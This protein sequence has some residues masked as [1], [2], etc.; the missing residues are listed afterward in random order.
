MHLLGYDIGSSSIKGTIIDA[1]TGGIIA[2]ASHPSKEMEIIAKKPGWAEQEPQVWWDNIVAVTGRLKKIA[3][4]K[5]DDIE[6]IGISYQMHG[7]VCVDI[8]HKSLRPSIIW[9]DSRA[10]PYGK[11][12]EEKIG[13][14]KCLETLL[15]LPGN[16]TAAKLAWVKENEPSTYKKIYKVMLPGDYAAMRM[17]G[18]ICTSIS[19]LSEGMFWDFKKQAVSEP[20]LKAF[21]FD[22]ELTARFTPSFSVN[23]TLTNGA[24]KELGLK[25]G[26][27]VA[28]RAGDQPNNAL[29]LNVLEPGE[30]ATTAGTSGVVYGVSDKPTYDTQ[31]RVNTFVHV[32]HSETSP[33]YGTLMCLNGTGILNRWIRDNMGAGLSYEAINTIAAAVEPGSGGLFIHPYGNGAERT[34]ANMDIGASVAALSFTTHSNRNFYR[35]GQEG[36][37]YALNYG[38]EI[39]KDMGIKVKKVRAGR[40]NMFLSPV[41]R[42]IFAAVTGAVVELYETDGSQGAARGAGIGAGIYRDA[43]EAFV[44]LKPLGVTEPDKRLKAA[45]AGLYGEWKRM[46]VEK[47]AVRG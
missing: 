14:K 41:F 4:K 33:R 10:V 8:N 45:Y 22:R 26:I 23:G 7:L 1:Q 32:N 9:C 21:G 42:E 28:Y 25:P 43:K 16:F 30:L 15:N 38:I 29:S 6:A 24:A 17:T 36:I 34:L 27:K 13:V 39:M 37:V 47:L 2:A 35:A 5:A 44:G 18:E 19:G 31:S 3:G 20:I 40:A 11:K 46:L 12:A